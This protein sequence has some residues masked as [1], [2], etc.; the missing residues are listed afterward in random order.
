MLQVQ[1]VCVDYGGFRAVNEVSLAVEAGA[2]VGIQADMQHDGIVGEIALVSVSPPV[3]GRDMHLDVALELFPVQHDL[4]LQKIRPG[5]FVPAPRRFDG[6]GFSGHCP[7]E[8]G[9]KHAFEPDRLRQPLRDA[10]R[11]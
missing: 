8:L 7:H 3:A 1:Q 4:G 2:I 6:Q 5:A 10:G 11:G 9:P